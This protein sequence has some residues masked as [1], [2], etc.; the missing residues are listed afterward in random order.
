MGRLS[1]A[2]SDDP[3]SYKTSMP[4]AFRRTLLIAVPLLVLLLVAV[5]AFLLA[6]GDDLKSRSAQIPVGMSREQVESILGPPV[7]T[8]GRTGGRGT[9]LAWVDQ[10][11]QV[12]VL[13][14]PDGRA[15]SVSC[16][17]SDSFLRRT[18]GRVIPLPQ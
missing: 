4:P 18:V 3:A 6:G 7:L 12:D 11:W 17:P 8:L 2:W 13:T 10:L 14:A 5:T 16:K 9:L 15:E 1:G